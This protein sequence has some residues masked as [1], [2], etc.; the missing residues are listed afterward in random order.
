MTITDTQSNRNNKKDNLLTLN[1]KPFG[2]GVFVR[3]S[4]LYKVFNFFAIFTRKVQKR[5]PFEFSRFCYVKID[6]KFL[7]DI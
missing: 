1:H 5:L 7:V 6:N 3:V 2:C 4:I